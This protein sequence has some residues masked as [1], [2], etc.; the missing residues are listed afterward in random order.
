MAIALLGLTLL[1][2]RFPA[3]KDPS[4]RL[5]NIAI[6]FARLVPAIF[7]APVVASSMVAF[8][9]RLGLPAVTNPAWPPVAAAVAYILAMDLGE[10]LFHRAQ[11]AIPFLWRMHSL[12]HS[13]PCMNATTTDRNWWGDSLIKALTIWPVAAIL[14]RPSVTT[15]TVYAALSAY[16]YFS[17]ANLRVSFGRLS[18]LLNSPSYHRTHHSS[19]PAHHG[20]N[21]AALFPIFDVILGSYRPAA[22]FPPTGLDHRPETL[23]HALVWPFLPEPE[24]PPVTEGRTT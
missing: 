19:D 15:L 6:L 21:F 17:H 7:M 4:Q 14:F 12:H 10:Y 2:G 11:H 8:A 1:E 18:W 5:L 9:D 24:G 13:D 20:A 3:R 23:V 22:V 16:N